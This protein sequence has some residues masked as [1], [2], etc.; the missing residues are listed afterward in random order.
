MTCADFVP[1]TCYETFLSRSRSLYRRVLGRK[2]MRCVGPQV[3]N[4]LPLALALRS[5]TFWRAVVRMIRALFRFLSVMVASLSTKPTA[6]YYCQ[7]HACL[8]RQ[9]SPYAR[10]S[11]HLASRMQHL[12]YRLLAV[13]SISYL[14]PYIIIV[15]SQHNVLVASGSCTGGCCCRWFYDRGFFSDAEAW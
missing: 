10:L 6:H 9:R 2:I 14:L 5:Q 3:L 12:A 13:Y 7:A 4:N 15:D 8:S 1:S 11:E